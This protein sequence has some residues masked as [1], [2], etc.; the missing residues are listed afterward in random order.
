MNLIQTILYT[1]IQYIHIIVE[2]KF[3]PK[4]AVSVVDRNLFLF[5]VSIFFILELW[6]LVMFFSSYYIFWPS[7]TK[8]KTMMNMVFLDAKK[9]NNRWIHVIKIRTCPYD[10]YL[11]TIEVIKINHRNTLSI[12]FMCVKYGSD[13]SAWFQNN[14]LKINEAEDSIN[15]RM[16]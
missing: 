10:S 1:Y 8:I 11:I 12:N 13:F 3:L 2:I 15:W 16:Y 5:N 7:I 14:K 9:I 6:F 4:F